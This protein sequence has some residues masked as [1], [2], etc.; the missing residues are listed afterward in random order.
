MFLFMAWFVGL[1]G[2]GANAF[3]LERRGVLL[4]LSF[5]TPRWSLLLA[6]N[7]GTLLLRVPGFLMLLL[8]GLILAPAAFLLPAAA[9]ALATFLIASGLDNYMSIRYPAP[10]APPGRSAH[11]GGAAGG[12]GLAG[13]VLG[14]FLMG[15]TFVL[16]FPFVFLVLFP[17]LFHDLRFWAVT[18]PLALAGAAAVYAMMVAGAAKTLLRREPELLER[19]LV[20]E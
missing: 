20:E 5:P 18:V 9:I 3:G 4:L 10:V 19:I 1:S 8:G 11:G 15:A 14:L 2:L 12:R 7:L 17:V 16:S 13:A 6:K